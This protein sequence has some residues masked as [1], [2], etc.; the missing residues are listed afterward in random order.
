MKTKTLTGLVLLSLFSFGCAGTK[1]HFDDAPIDQLDLSQ[2]R[3]VKAG[4]SG[5]LLF[6]LIPIKINDRH[7]HAYG[8][9]K[10]KAN[11]AY[12]TDIKIQDSWKFVFIGEKHGTI[13]TATAYPDKRMLSTPLAK[14]LDEL[15][16]LHD[17]G[18]LSDAEYE[19]SR[20]KALGN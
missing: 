10:D 17:I 2:G 1:V 12:L 20:K 15:K 7:A 13:I 19:E 9:L 6:H 4:A 14:K 18:V 8:R 11:G 16:T 3:T 5:L